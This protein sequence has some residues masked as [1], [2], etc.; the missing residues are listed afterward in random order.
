VGEKGKILLNR[1]LGRIDVYRDHGKN[2]DV[3]DQKP[4]RFENSHFGADHHLI[5][6]LDRFCRSGVSP[7]TARE[8][9]GSARLVEA[10]HLSVNAGGELVSM[11]DV[12]GA[13]LL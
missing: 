1:H 13:E 4:D 6:E 10:S 9:L 2:H 8:G 5:E 11:S 3:L 7:V 12:A